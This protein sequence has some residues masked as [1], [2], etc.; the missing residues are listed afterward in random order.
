MK[1][2]MDLVRTILLLVEDNPD[3]VMETIP[4][5]PEYTKDQVAE[6]IRLLVEGD[7]LTATDA[8]SKDEADFFY[9]RLTWRG[10]DF[11]DSVRDSEIWRKTKSAAKRIGSWSIATLGE[12]AKGYVKQRVVEFGLPIG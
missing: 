4:E 2:D 10:H 1:R 6:H 8:S 11:I 12:I 3:A 9:I 7:M 5:I